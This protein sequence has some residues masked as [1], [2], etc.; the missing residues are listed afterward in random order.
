[1]ASSL[2]NTAHAVRRCNLKLHF[3]ITLCLLIFRQV[4]DYSSS[5]QYSECCWF[6][7]KTGSVSHHLCTLIQDHTLFCQQALHPQG[8]WNV[9]CPCFSVEEPASHFPTKRAPFLDSFHQK[10]KSTSSDNMG[11]NTLLF[12]VLTVT[13]IFFS[14]TQWLSVFSPVFINIKS[15]QNENYRLKILQKVCLKFAPRVTNDL[16]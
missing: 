9:Y 13:L 12:F 16:E 11:N 4:I 5:T 2:R 14:I 6:L 8:D 3:N 1:M 7:P 15:A 10:K